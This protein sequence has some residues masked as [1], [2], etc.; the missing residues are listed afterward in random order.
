MNY[1]IEMDQ[2]YEQGI[3]DDALGSQLRA[4]HVHHVEDDGNNPNDVAINMLSQRVSHSSNLND[5]P[6]H[7]IDD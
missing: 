7:K 3:V 1:Y 6:V 4:P 5:H 2:G